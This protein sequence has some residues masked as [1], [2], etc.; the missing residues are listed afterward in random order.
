M[1]HDTDGLRAPRNADAWLHE[2]MRT[3]TSRPLAEFAGAINDR[4][5]YVMA[6]SPSI[7][8]SIPACFA[9]PPRH[10]RAAHSVHIFRH[11]KKGP[12]A[13]TSGPLDQGR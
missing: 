4:R 1:L 5:G 12:D 3:H 13:D 8:H 9:R 7:M 2:L 10:R 6:Q 11:T